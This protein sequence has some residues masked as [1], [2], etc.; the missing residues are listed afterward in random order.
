MTD[1][2]TESS[3]FS[4]KYFTLGTENPVRVKFNQAGHQINAEVPDPE[5]QDLK[6]QTTLLSRLATSPDATEIDRDTFDQ[7]CR[8]IYGQKKNNG[9]ELRL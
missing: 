4:Y 8:D 2:K 7:L 3:E 9:Q 1:H 5:T 6:I